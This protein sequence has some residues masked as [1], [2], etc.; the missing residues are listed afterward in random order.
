MQFVQNVPLMSIMLSMF[1]GIISSVLSGK[2]ARRINAVMLIIVTALSAWLLVFLL[3]S[4]IGSYTY[5][6]GHFPAPWGNEV[7]AGVLEAG[8]ACFFCIIMLLSLWGGR[9]KLDMEVE[10]T[11]HNIYY[12]LADLLLGSILALIYTYPAAAAIYGNNR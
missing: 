4:D 2:I 12:I 10:H 3:Q 11:K 1:S 9:H 5:M 6:M 7:R 8:T